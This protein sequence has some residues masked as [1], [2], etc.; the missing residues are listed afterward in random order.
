MFSSVLC[1]KKPELIYLVSS[2]VLPNKCTWRDGVA[3]TL[4]ARVWEVSTSN[5]GNFDRVILCFPQY[6]QTDCDINLNESFN[7]NYVYF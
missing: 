3:V 7:L 5:L 6:R 2:S 4:W 1:K